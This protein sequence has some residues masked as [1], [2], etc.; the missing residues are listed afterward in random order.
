MDE[1]NFNNEQNRTNGTYENTPADYNDGYNDIS[2]NSSETDTHQPENI[3]SSSQPQQPS[4]AIN[5]QPV[6]YS[7]TQE[8]QTINL[9]QYN[10]ANQQNYT[11]PQYH[12]ANPQYNSVNQQPP[13]KSKNGKKVALIVGALALTL[14]VG[15]GGGLLGAYLLGN[16]GGVSVA[17]NTS[18]PENSKTENSNSGLTI[19]QASDDEVKPTT[20]QEVAEKTLDS[21]VEI[22]TE[23][24]EYDSFYGQY[25]AKGAG[26]GVIISADGY[27]ITNNHVVEGATSV[28]V[29]LTNEKSYDAKVIGTDSTLDVALIKIEETNLKPATFGD[30]SKLKVGQTAIAIGNPLGKL[31]GTVTDGIISALDREIELDGKTMTLLQTNAAINPGNSGGGLFDSNG[32]LIGIVVAKSTSSSNGTSVEGLGFAIPVNNITD[33]LDD[34][35]TSGYV[36]GRPTLGVTLVDVD[37]EQKQF[38]YRVDKLGAY[39]SSLVSGG[40]AEKA[41]IKVG[42]CITKIGDKEVST[43]S[44][45]KAELTKHKAGEKIKITVDRDGK[46]KIFDVTLGESIPEESSTEESSSY[47]GNDPDDIFRYYFGNGG[48]LG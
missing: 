42:D 4:Q 16:N 37:T 11:V 25:V 30:S 3:Y 21:V 38:M 46:E 6:H 39:V 43:S 18:N 2:S 7:S 35:R 34:L 47:F 33:I 24:T 44:E 9:P 45:I 15:L 22:T 5:T 19:I 23:S 31:G 36:T 17:T 41:G 48:S 13:K 8:T 20:T 26:S 1:N 29:R 12:N 10:A 32:N 28:K 27:I 14:C 40:A